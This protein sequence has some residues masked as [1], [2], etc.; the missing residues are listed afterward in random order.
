MTSAVKESVVS[1]VAVRQVPFTAIESPMES[2]GV[3]TGAWIVRTDDVSPFVIAV[4]LPS[5]ATKPV[6]INDS[7]LCNGN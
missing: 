1:E 6:N 2:S 3:R 5:S 7:P 4:T